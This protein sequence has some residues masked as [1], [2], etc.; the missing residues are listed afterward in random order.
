MTH[1]QGRPERAGLVAQSPV[2]HPQWGGLCLHSESAH[3]GTLTQGPASAGH[4]SSVGP[5]PGLSSMP[6]SL[7]S[8]F[9][10]CKP[11][12]RQPCVAN[13]GCLEMGP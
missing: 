7:L 11:T 10:L 8:D 3:R 2:P 9:S 12:A 5:P 4:V 1:V 6:Y 13:A